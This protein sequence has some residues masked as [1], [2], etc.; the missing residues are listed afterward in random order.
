M[1]LSF[2]RSKVSPHGTS[3]LR[4]FASVSTMKVIE[5][6]FSRILVY[7]STR[8]VRLSKRDETR[9]ICRC[10]R[11]NAPSWRTLVAIYRHVRDFRMW[12]AHVPSLI[13]LPAND[14]CSQ[15]LTSVANFTWNC[16]K[17]LPSS[18]RVVLCSI[19]P[20]LLSLCVSLSL[21]FVLPRSN[22]IQ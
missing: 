15:F 19:T 22:T 2:I 17:S 3:H 12:T 14:S 4:F 6:D 10:S 11:E 13:F 7:Q 18:Q 20:P 1:A 16:R 9:D 8:R 5:R 21:S